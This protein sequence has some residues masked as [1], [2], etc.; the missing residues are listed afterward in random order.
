MDYE[1]IVVGGGIAGLT[2]SMYLA[3]LKV[4]VLVIS[5]DLGG[6]LKSVSKLNNYP[7]FDGVEGIKLVKDVLDIVQRLGVEILIDEVIRLGE[8]NGG[9]YV[10]T[11][12][13]EKLTSRALILAIGKR[14]RKLGV[15][16]EE[17]LVG[18]GVSYC[19][20]CD[21][22]LAR[23]RKVALVGYGRH[24]INSLK[25]LKEYASEVYLLSPKS[26]AG[27]SEEELRQLVSQGIHVI[28]SVKIKEIN[29]KY[30]LENIVLERKG[31]EIVFKVDMLFVELG[32]ITATDIL[33]NF[34][35][36]NSRGEVVIDKYC[37]TSRKGVF[38]AGDITDIPFKQAVIAAGQ[39]AIAALSAYRYLRS[40]SN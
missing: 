12:S 21:A 36:L 16:G 15:P 1:V 26:N 7:G 20:L 11:K 34:V 23:N 22:P 27:L 14:P 31:R 18:K 32:Y 17:E 33:R 10:L 13:G 6:Q 8:E 19:I 28:D 9:F 29:G 5:I 4:D 40:K 24:T 3:R 2:A 25:L 35:E 30:R 37:E 39:G 38:A